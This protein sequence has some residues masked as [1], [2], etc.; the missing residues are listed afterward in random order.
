M[1]G[2][3]PSEIKWQRQH[4]GPA[5]LCL[6]AYPKEITVNEKKNL[7]DVVYKSQKLA[8]NFI[9]QATKEIV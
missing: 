8:N 2:K 5:S 7:K 4:F 1:L 6:S 3:K 9:A